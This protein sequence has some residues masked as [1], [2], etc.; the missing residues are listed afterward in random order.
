MIVEMTRDGG[1]R[2]EGT[3]QDLRNLAGWLLKAVR[4]GEV[5]PAFLMDA[6]VSNIE[7]T[8]RDPLELD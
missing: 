7:I 3:E 6:G 5:A 4:E 2:I 1:M 8:C